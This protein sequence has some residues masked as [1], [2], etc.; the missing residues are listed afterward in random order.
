MHWKTP[1]G[2]C[3]KLYGRVRLLRPWP[4]GFL[5]ELGGWLGLWC[6]DAAL[7]V[8]EGFSIDYG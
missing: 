6:F 2:S 1:A 3:F 4:K 8:P 5:V 7:G